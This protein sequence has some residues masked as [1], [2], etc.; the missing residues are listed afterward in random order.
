M[1]NLYKY[2]GFAGCLRKCRECREKEEEIS[3]KRHAEICLEEE[4]K[5]IE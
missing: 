5:K 4:I 3:D 2:M 1:L